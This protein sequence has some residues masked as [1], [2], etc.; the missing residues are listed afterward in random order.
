MASLADVFEGRAR[1]CVEP[2]D[3]RFGMSSMPNDSVDAIVCDPPY[4]LGFMGKRWDAS[5]IAF[6]VAMWAEALRVLKPGG[7]LV[8]FGGTRTY[9]RMACAIEDAGWEVR[10]CLA[11]M[12]GSG[13]PKSLDV[14]KQLDK[15][16]G[17][18]RGRA[19]AVASDNAAM[20]GPNYA[21]TE[22]GGPIT[23]AAAAAAGYGTA[24]KPAFEPAILARKPLDGTVSANWM[25]H[26]TGA[27][28]IDG[29]RIGDEV[30]INEPMGAPE[31]SY[32]DGDGGRW[33][34]AGESPPRRS[35]RGSPRRPNR[36]PPRHVRRRCPPCG[37]RGRHVRCDRLCG[38]CAGG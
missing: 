26:G 38:E 25:E 3:C 4:E 19:G 10:D 13:F 9:H 30:L 28:N 22:K 35:R 37:L 29:C 12:Y 33:S 8:A 6:D 36:R 31:N 27:I 34:M 23:A 21:R 18:W 7:H 11:W 32:G 16:A 5:G 14:A 24:L 20:G 17:H 15:N 1:Y 2:C